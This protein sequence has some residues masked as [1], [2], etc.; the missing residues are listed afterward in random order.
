MPRPVP[1]QVI[2]RPAD[3]R[4]GG[5]PPWADLPPER[6]A[7]IGLAQ[8]L[9]ALAAA[10]QAGPAPD[11]VGTDGIFEAPVVGEAPS[12][13]RQ[14][15]SAVLA[16]LF[17]EDG[18]ARIVLTR[19]SVDLRTHQGQVSFPG[20]RIEPGE[21]PTAAAL[22]EAFEEVGLDPA[23]VRT[24][25]WLLPLLT[26]VSSSFILPVLG[27][28]DARPQLQPNPSEVERIFDVSLADLA[29]LTIFHEERWRVPGRVIEGSDDNS[30]PVWFFEVAG[31]MIWGAT[32]RMLHE[33]L[34]I[35]L[36]DR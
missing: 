12:L 6:R 19:R 28:L 26:M 11:D 4:P 27:T 8:V 7:S 22:R 16:A 3:W 36:A 2:P 31:E 15:N 24:V 32:A 18:E 33:L 21:D 5:P 34:D 13:P 1:P 10:G 23:L 17:D 25:G 29:D 30:F 35:V 9:N 14:V 20:G